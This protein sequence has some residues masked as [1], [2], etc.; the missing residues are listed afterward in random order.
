M[1]LTPHHIL[2][3]VAIGIGAS[4]L[5]D[6]WNLLLKRVVGISSLNYC[7]LGRWLLHMPE[8][9]FS[10]VS[11]SA[12]PQRRFECSTGWLAHYSIG[13]AFALVFLALQSGD[14]LAHPT[15]LPALLY[16]IATVVFPLGIMQPALGLGIA[17]SRTPKPAQARLKSLAT[18][19]VF[20]IGLYLCALVARHLLPAA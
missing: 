2:G 10:H 6:A 13:V 9:T 7:V 17:A 11:I 8:G 15:L 4:V 5:M 19:T 12:A 20:G 14:W 16:G 1:S 3:A 18:H